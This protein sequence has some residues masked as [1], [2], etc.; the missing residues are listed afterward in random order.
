MW[1][2]SISRV[3]LPAKS[4]QWAL[5]EYVGDT[6]GMGFLYPAQSISNFESGFDVAYVH[7]DATPR[8]LPLR[9]IWPGFAINTIF[10]AA[11]L[12]LLFAAFGQIRRR[13]R[14][15]RGLC[16]ACAYPVGESAVCTECGKA[17]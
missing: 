13:R 15:K 6:R 2:R 5:Y 11:V 10:Y 14:I 3:G 12:W 17:L 9:P 16:P 8:R 7:S 1:M 4:M